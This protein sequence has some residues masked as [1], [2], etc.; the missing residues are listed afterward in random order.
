M[1]WA[2]LNQAEAF[3]ESKWLKADMSEI[4]GI[5][6]AHK[7]TGSGDWQYQ[8]LGMWTDAERTAPANAAYVDYRLVFLSAG[9]ADTA[10]GNVWWDAAELNTSVIPEPTS[11]L[12]LGSGLVGLLGLRKRTTK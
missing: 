7:T 4:G 9:H 2:N 3:I 8:D 6:T 1:K 12:L 10:T 11:L 5:G